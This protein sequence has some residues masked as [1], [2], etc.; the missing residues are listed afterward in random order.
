MKKRSKIE[1]ADKMIHELFDYVNWKLNVNLSCLEI[2]LYATTVVSAENN[3]YS[4][5]KPWT[6]SQPSVLSMTMKGRSLS[7]LMAFEKQYEALADP[8][9][10]LH[11][12]RFDH[13]FDG[14]YTPTQVFGKPSTNAHTGYR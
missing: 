13:L 10:F 1:T 3:D 14:I 5:P 12:N 4:L 6:T 9:S 7:V 2:I 11:T 8:V